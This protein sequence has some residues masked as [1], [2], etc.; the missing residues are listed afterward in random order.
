MENGQRQLPLCGRYLIF[1]VKNGAA[2]QKV[3]ISVDGQVQREFFI[4]LADAQPDFW[5]FTDMSP[6]QG[7][8]AT[9]QVA[10]LPPT[11]SGLLAIVCADSAPGADDRYQEASRPQFHFSSRRGWLNDPNGL[12]YY[13]GEYHL[14]YQHNPYGVQWENMHWGHAVSPDLVHWQELPAALYP[15]SQAKGHAYSGSVVVDHANSAGFGQGT[16]PAMIAAFT[17]TACGEALAYSN[18]C[19]RSWS[20]A[21]DNPVVR[22]EGRDPK[23]FWYS[24]GQ[25]WVMAL[26]DIRE[27]KHGIAFLT[28]ADL[29][30]WQRQS[31]LDGFF[32]CP[33]LFPLPVSGEPHTVVWVLSGAD[34]NYRLGDFDGKT[35]IPISAKLPFQYGNAYYAAQTYNEIPAEDGRRIQI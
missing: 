32:E 24:A 23:V 6:W 26:Y 1:P 3:Q 19:G 35:F 4:E 18:D 7:K 14:F 9:I 12:V 15:F 27:G 29:K 33:D 10:G 22:H 17:D 5:V 16:A 2:K 34:G 8:T 31:W 30:T 20:Y 21:P 11:A 13:Q 25:H 28:S